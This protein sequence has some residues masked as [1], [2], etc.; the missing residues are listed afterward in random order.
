[1]GPFEMIVLVVL[2]SV[3]AG[4]FSK[5]LKARA[6]NGTMSTEQAARLGKLEE[7]VRALE[8]VVGDSSFELK[9][10]LRELER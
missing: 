8:A 1:M 10:K 2:I 6:G 7:R 5:Y 3:G 9:Q 4:V